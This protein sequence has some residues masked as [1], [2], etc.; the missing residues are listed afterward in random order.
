MRV[1]LYTFHYSL[2]K[3]FHA[4]SQQRMVPDW[5]TLEAKPAAAIA[6]HSLEPFLSRYGGIYEHCSAEHDIKWLWQTHITAE[7]SSLSFTRN[8]SHSQ[9]KKFGRTSEHR[10]TE[11]LLNWFPLLE[12]CPWEQPAHLPSC[13]WQHLSHKPMGS[14]WF[15]SNAW[16][17][18]S[19]GLCGGVFW[20]V[21]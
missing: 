13:Y 18:F 1:F 11:Q 10:V 9:I 12:V 15:Q 4:L 7:K 3:P 2:E 17:G 14:V 21:G 20:L 16:V 19:A 8:H 5:A 6:Q